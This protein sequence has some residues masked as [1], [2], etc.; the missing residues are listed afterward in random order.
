MSE[1][2]KYKAEAADRWGGTDAYKE[3]SE[4]AR[5]YSKDKWNNAAAGLDNI[6]AE[7]ALLLKGGNP[8]GSDGAQALIKKL[9][10]YITENFYNC[11][12]EILAGLG[13]MYV[14]DERFKKNIDKHE[15]GTAQFICDA[16]GIYC[17]KQ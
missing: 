9:K 12:D 3:Y 10:R 8:P 17:N 16:I 4:K 13:Q 14:C 15:S 7:F 1:F 11:T 5:G 6:M 2:E